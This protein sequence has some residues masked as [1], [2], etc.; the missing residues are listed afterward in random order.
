MPK[1]HRLLYRAGLVAVMSVVSLLRAPRAQA[2]AANMC[3]HTYYCADTCSG[4]MGDLDC[5]FC[6]FPQCGFDPRCADGTGGAYSFG[7]YCGA[8]S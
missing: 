7:L 8:A 5:T 3:D 4:T 1:P 6:G 2:A